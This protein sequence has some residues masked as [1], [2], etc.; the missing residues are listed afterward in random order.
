MS[1]RR[2]GP[3][4]KLLAGAVLVVGLATAPA[5]PRALTA[6]ALVSMAVV[7]A[8]RPKLGVLA[9]RGLPALGVILALLLPS[10]L[11]GERARA[12]LVGG[13]ALTATL[14]ALAVASTLAAHEVPGALGA[15]GVP[16]ALASVTATMLRQLGAVRDEGRR[17]ALA[18]E[19]R[20]ARGAGFGAGTVAA[21]LVRTAERAE[22]VELAA[23]LRGS[24]PRGEAGRA[25]LRAADAL[26][27]LA[28]AAGG[29]LAHLA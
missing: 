4:G 24:T 5:S 25:R 29:A 27:V 26:L 17:L 13:R 1:A 11:A 9:R 8:T 10:L 20:G 28:G 15:L 7:I 12:L 14:A 16:G 21:L 6:N 18:R 2:A 3:A 22:R 19:L 23:R